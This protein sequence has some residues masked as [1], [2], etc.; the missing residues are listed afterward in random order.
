M[1]NNSCYKLI[2]IDDISVGW[3][4]ST[5]ETHVFTKDE[6]IHKVAPLKEEQFICKCLSEV[7]LTLLTEGEPS[8]YVKY[9]VKLQNHEGDTCVFM[10]DSLFVCLLKAFVLYHYSIKRG[11]NVTQG[12][13]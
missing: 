11:L 9:I 7:S 8:K 2:F 5:G 10:G 4:S 1:F 6:A 13:D 12:I 3:I